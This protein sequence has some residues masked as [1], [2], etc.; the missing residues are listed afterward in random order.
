MFDHH[1]HH[2]HHQQQQEY[3]LNFNQLRKNQGSK[4]NNK[5][6]III[7]LNECVGWWS[8]T[9]FRLLLLL[10]KYQIFTK[11]RWLKD[12]DFCFFLSISQCQWQPP[13]ATK[14]INFCYLALLLV[15]SY[16]F[17]AE[18]NQPR[19]KRST[20]LFGCDHHH[21]REKKT[22]K[23]RRLFKTSLDLSVC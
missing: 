2:H 5:N 6:F 17:L 4:K 13:S 21:H 3:C 8:G 15:Y 14:F 10:I 1:R 16:L 18:E 11:T 22:E 23:I 7:I 20:I 19:K 12:D 9:I